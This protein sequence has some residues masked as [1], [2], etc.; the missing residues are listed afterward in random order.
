MKEF[1]FAYM[2]NKVVVQLDD[3]NVNVKIGPF[4]KKNFPFTSIQHYYVFNNDTYVSLFITYTETSGKTKKVQLIS[5]NGEAGFLQLVNELN[6]R[7]PAKSLNNLTE[8]EAFAIM[9]TA[10]PK[11]W[12]PLLAFGIIFL[13]MAGIFYPGLRHYFDFGFTDAT[14][15]EVA[16]KADLGTRNISI[17]GMVLGDMGL[18]ETTTTTRRGSTTT[19]VSIYVPVVD[20]DWE[21]GEPVEVF[22]SFDELSDSE[23][24]EML[25]AGEHIGVIRD[26]AWEGIGQSEID[27]FKNEYGLEVA[28]KPVLVEITGT[29]RNDAWA[30]WGLLITTAILGIVFLVIALKKR[31]G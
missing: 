22:L 11:K 30:L 12:A 18:Q 13:V 7:I 25:G 26:I 20:E 8:K 24:E 27:F 19:T 2:T 29:D 21:E 6:A 17:S 5:A 4:I 14:V 28:E 1:S 23:Y 16:Q 15:T 10:N 31:K 9:K 3:F